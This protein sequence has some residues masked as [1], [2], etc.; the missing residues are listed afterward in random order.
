MTDKQKRP[1]AE[2][3]GRECPERAHDDDLQTAKVNHNSYPDNEYAKCLNTTDPDDARLDRLDRAR[4]VRGFY[5]RMDSV[6]PRRSVESV[7][8]ELAATVE[9][10]NSAVGEDRALLHRQILALRALLG[11]KGGING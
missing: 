4:R 9:E 8:A 1:P 2:P 11:G 5:G 7:V 3:N 6:K 10:A